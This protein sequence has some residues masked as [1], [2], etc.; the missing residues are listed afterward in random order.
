MP[1]KGEIKKKEFYG[2]PQVFGY[3]YVRRNNI[4]V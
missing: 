3:N 1:H 2:K 4:M